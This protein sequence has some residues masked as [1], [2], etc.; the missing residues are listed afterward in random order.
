MVRIFDIDN[1][2]DVDWDKV[3]DPSLRDPPPVDNTTGNTPN[4]DEI[5]DPS[6]SPPLELGS[7]TAQPP[8]QSLSLVSTTPVTVQ[9]AVTPATTSSPP[10]N[11]PVVQASEQSQLPTSAT[12]TATV[13][14]TGISSQDVT[15]SR[16]RKNSA[17]GTV[18][19]TQTATRGK[20]RKASDLLVN[21][22]GGP[23]KRVTRSSAP[24]AAP[25]QK[26]KPTVNSERPPDGKF[27]T[28]VTESSSES[29]EESALSE[30][31][32]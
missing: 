8:S 12:A 6:L 30:L 7:S 18:E 3:I 26:K 13:Q 19:R 16:K 21:N 29:A 28:Y 32:D 4:W 10:D 24:K 11:P 25:T 14:T 27:F 15:N 1:S 2:D 23:Q 31:S 9:S 22:V 17:V 20:R 5:I